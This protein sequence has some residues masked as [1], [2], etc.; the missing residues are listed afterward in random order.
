[1]WACTCLQRKPFKKKNGTKNVAQLSARVKVQWFPTIKCL[2]ESYASVNSTCA[3]PPQY[4]P[5]AAVALGR[6]GWGGGI[7]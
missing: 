5:Q 2:H 1:M 7:D 4:P 3:Q 6:R